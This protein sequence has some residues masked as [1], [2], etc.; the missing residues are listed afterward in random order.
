[1]ARSR[2]RRVEP[3]TL[4]QIDAAAYCGV[5]VAYF[6]EELKAGNGPQA[7]NPRRR[8]DPDRKSLDRYAMEDLDEWIRLNGLRPRQEATPEPEAGAA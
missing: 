5:G 8:R 7:F 4:C 2:R 1:M 6:R 3:E